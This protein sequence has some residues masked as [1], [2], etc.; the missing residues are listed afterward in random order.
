[1][2]HAAHGTSLTYTVAGMDCAHCVQKVEGAVA[3]LPGTASVQTSFTRQT[4]DL[5]LDEAQ[6]PRAHLEQTL[7]ALGYAPTLHAPETPIPTTEAPWW[8]APAARTVLVSG[9]LLLAAYLLSF[10]APTLAP[11]FYAAATLAGTLPLA[12]KAW[13]ATRLGQPFGI[14]TLVALAALGAL[15]IGEYAEG[16]VV[17]FLFAVGEYLEGVAA[18][19]AR[20]GI[21]ALLNLTPKTALLL[22]GQALREVR[23][24]T[25]RVGE[26]VR[27]RPG[28]R[29]PA[30]GTIVDGESAVDDSPIT[31]ESV[32]VHKATGDAVYAGSINTDGVLTVRVDRAAHENTVARIIHMVEA[33]E[34]RKARVSRLIDRFSHVYTPFVVLIAALTAVLPPL[35]AGAAWDTW[36]Y[37][38]LSLLLIGCPCALVLSVPAAV[39]SA[40]SAGA[41]RGL[42]V[43][44]GA[45]LEA[46]AGVR[47]VAFDKTGTLTTGH[48]RVTDVHPL[49]G[50][51]DEALAL[52][53]AVE[54]GSSHP[55]ARAIVEHAAHLGVAVPAAQEARALPGRAVTARIGGREITV[56]SPR[57]VST[58]APLP[59]GVQ[60]DIA[61]LEAA[62]KTVVIVLDGVTPRALIALRDEPRADTPAA[63][64]RLRALGVEAVMLT[65]DNAR[66]ANAVAAPLGLRVH[67]DLLP[68]DKLTRLEALAGAGRVAMVGDGIN[69]APA[70]ARADVGIAM[71]GGTD[72]ALE[73]A[74]A[75]LLR[76]GVLGV[77][78]LVALARATLR[79]I[80]QN[81]AF[82][83]GLKAVFLVTTLLGVTGLWP[84]ILADTGATMLVTANAL[85]LLRWREAA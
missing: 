82:A 78:A 65:G 8:G 58:L 66:T 46:L 68:E 29:V 34:E 12:R 18:G 39:T 50:R 28:D 42:L 40:I 32:P 60:A 67:A 55:L 24:D 47:L 44:G 79:N 9:T 77:P 2:S 22:E 38:A 56:G 49:H 53:A 19:R 81:V 7:R 41:R 14:N 21:R 10:A 11:V 27:V 51:A 3:R 25:L 23:A 57:H 6:T 69:D 43:K 84:A 64:A 48:P 30:D 74:D 61:A 37:R 26:R 15:V 31:G 5:E 54:A 33:A 63:L 36:V 62:G 72:V 4:L 73:T 70:L 1:M 83:L 17:V 75:A 71:G 45:A 52:A 20:A 16:A 35:L 13:A 59:E 80:R 76:G 85:R